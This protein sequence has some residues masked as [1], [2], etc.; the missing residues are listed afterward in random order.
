MGFLIYDL[1]FLVL[2]LVFFSLFLY[3]RKK[4]LKREG[5]LFLYRTKWGMKLIDKVGEKYKKTLKVLSYISITTGYFLMIGIFYVVYTIVKIYFFSPAIV[6]AIKVPPILPLVP[7]LPQ[8][9]RLDF[10]P[11]FYFTYWI[12]IIAIIA[13][14]HEF[15]HGIFMKKYNIKIKSTGFAFFP[16]FFPI[17]PAAFVEQD[18][19][20]M[21]KSKKFE[22]MAVLS[23][24]TF[25][26]VL[27]AILFFIILFLFFS[28]A[29]T[30]AGIIFDTYA[31][32]EIAIMGI[33]AINGIAI[34]NASYNQI[35]NLTDE[36]G[37]N[38]VE[39]GGEEYL[40]TKEILEEQEDNEGSIFVY[41]DAPAIQENLSRIII[42]INGVEITSLDKLVIELDKYSPRDEVV[43]KTKTEEGFEEKSLVLEEHPERPGKAWV[44]IGFYN[45]ERSGFFGKIVNTL[46]SFKKPNVYY[47]P[48]F[49]EISLF[50]Y[51]LLW[52]LIL[53]SISVALI[54]ML[55]MGI[56]D[57]G[58]FFYLTILTLTKSEKTAK[59]WIRFSTQ[60]FLFILILLLVFWG[61][62]FFR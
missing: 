44:G 32:S 7:Y 46:S 51:N 52:W 38:E 40:A 21:S 18:E 4:N 10:L 3:T 25:A 48:K 1:V 26:N 27:V 37:F 16:Y 56:F 13:I 19:K 61:I 58:R 15:A 9:F 14:S 29:F 54:N 53:I 5:L 36:T 6:R 50:I 49:G 62:S 35:L 24:G 12:V 60:F 45:H 11:P 59:K 30:P 42:G 2:F 17:F 23:A 39:A 55:P 28:L 31:T 22:Q 43:I 34:N 41:H 57:G 20:S 47:A 8:V 33:S